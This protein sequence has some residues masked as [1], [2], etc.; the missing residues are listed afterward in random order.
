MHIGVCVVTKPS[1][2]APSLRLDINPLPLL[3]ILTHPT[4][5]IVDILNTDNLITLPPG[6]QVLHSSEIET[7]SLPFFVEGC[8]EV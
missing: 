8:T 5:Y 7:H 1:T 6:F 4:L 3:Y 2:P